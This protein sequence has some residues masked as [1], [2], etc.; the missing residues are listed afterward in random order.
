MLEEMKDLDTLVAWPVTISYGI[1]PRVIDPL[2]HRLANYKS[3]GFPYVS[4]FRFSFWF[5]AKLIPAY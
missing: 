4:I 5:S 3:G 1:R 2:T